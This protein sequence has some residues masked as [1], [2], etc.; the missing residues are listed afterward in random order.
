MGRMTG[1]EAKKS[2][3]KNIITRAV[4]IESILESDTFVSDFT[5]GYVLLCSD[6]LTNYVDNS[7]ISECIL[8]AGSLSDAVTELIDKANSRGGGDNIT[9]ALIAY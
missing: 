8:N 3:H 7:E 6:G 4:G 2:T 9:A 1:E 5:S